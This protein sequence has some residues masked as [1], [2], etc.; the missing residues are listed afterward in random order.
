MGGGSGS[1]NYEQFKKGFAIKWWHKN[2]K[3]SF[4]A[5]YLIKNK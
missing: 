3:M 2:T 1:Q 4:N 5:I